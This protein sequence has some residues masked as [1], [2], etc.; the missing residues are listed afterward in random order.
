M[1]STTEITQY[2]PLHE[3]KSNGSSDKNNN[4]KQPITTPLSP[5]RKIKKKQQQ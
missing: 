1:E 2:E 4:V 3:L 5:L